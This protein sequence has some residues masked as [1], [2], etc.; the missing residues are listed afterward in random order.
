MIDENVHVGVCGVFAFY[1]LYDTAT[2]V[3]DILFK[4]PMGVKFVA[5]S[6]YQ[7]RFI[8]S[9]AVFMW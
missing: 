5:Y 7:V 1:E 9:G 6:T 8:V 4:V 3:G 2:S